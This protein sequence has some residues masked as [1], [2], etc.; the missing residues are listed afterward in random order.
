MDCETRPGSL[1]RCVFAVNPAHW[2]YRSGLSQSLSSL[3]LEQT[4]DASRQAVPMRELQPSESER[5]PHRGRFMTRTVGS[6]GVHYMLADAAGSSMIMLLLARG[7]AFS[8]ESFGIW[9]R[10]FGSAPASKADPHVSDVRAPAISSA[11]GPFNLKFTLFR[12]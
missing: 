6:L 4:S 12:H 10:V 5:Q 9:T 3:Q 8:N 7:R 11:R 2:H 1:S